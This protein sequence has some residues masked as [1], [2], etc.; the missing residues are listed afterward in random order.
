MLNNKIA[1]WVAILLLLF[2]TILYAYFFVNFAIHPFEDAAML[3]RYADHFADGHGIVWNIGEAPVDGATDFLFMVIVAVV[4]RFGLSIEAAVRALTIASHIGT[5]LLIYI[6]M[7]KVQGA[8]PIPAFISALYFAIGPGLLLSAAY[9]GT[10]FFVLAVAS[11]WIIAQT[12]IFSSGD[13]WSN[14]L[15]FALICLVTGLISQKAS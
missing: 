2:S 7:R 8:G 14:Y 13:K 1:D 15:Y 11:S 4:H 9:F 10:P 6:A 12:I 3:M 5:I